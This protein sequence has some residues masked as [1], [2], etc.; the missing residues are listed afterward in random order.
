MLPQLKRLKSC[1]LVQTCQ[2]STQPPPTEAL[3]E[4]KTLHYLELAG[5]A[6]I[7]SIMNR[8]LHLP[9]LRRLKLHCPG[10]C[11]G[12]DFLAMARVVMLRFETDFIFIRPYLNQNNFQYWMYIETLHRI[13][14]QL[15]RLLYHGRSLW[16]QFNSE[17]AQA[18]SLTEVDFLTTQNGIDLVNAKLGLIFAS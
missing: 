13:V 7:R 2:S 1:T 4:C 8:V 9:L 12:Y 10:R 11:R 16:Q 14:R 17:L 6:E 15:R 5:F 3:S 18:K